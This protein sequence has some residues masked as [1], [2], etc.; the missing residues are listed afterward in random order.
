MIEVIDKGLIEYS[1]ARAFQLQLFEKAL[2]DKKE[3]RKPAQYFIVCQ[4]PPVYTIGKSGSE[5]NILLNEKLLGAP[6]FKIER[7]GDVTFHGPGQIVGYPIL[8][9]EQL[10]IG[11][12]QYIDTLE[13][14]IVQVIAKYGL[15]GE[16]IST[17][18]G[19]W[20]DKDKPSVR[21]ICALGVRASR[22]IT[23]H[24]FAFNVNTDLGW[25]LKINPCGF[26]DKGVTS[27]AN[28]LKAEQNFENV[29]QE[30]IDKFLELF[31]Q[32]SA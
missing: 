5:E 16:R 12:K 17:A 3:S 18:S 22:H 19:V 32:K 2:L 4:H 14:V 30:V 28:E 8:D 27:L 13:E 10:N 20:L 31:D 1:E 15:K 25:F 23:M 26:T 29:K 7:G 9:L 6:V 24:G 21:K 11:L